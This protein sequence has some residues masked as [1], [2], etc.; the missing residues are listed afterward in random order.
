[1]L[2]GFQINHTDQ[3]LSGQPQQLPQSELAKLKQRQIGYM[4]CTFKDPPG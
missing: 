2:I 1:M 3:I 4:I